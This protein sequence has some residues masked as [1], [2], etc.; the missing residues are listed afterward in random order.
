M[1]KGKILGAIIGTCFGGPWGALCGA[2][3]GHYFVD[4]ASS[5][6]A[7]SED[8]IQRI[9]TL[10]IRAAA[11]MAKADGVVSQAELN[12]VETFFGQIN[13]PLAQVNRLKIEFNNAINSTQSLNSIVVEFAKVASQE[14]N[15][16]LF[17]TL[18]QIAIAD[19]AISTKEKSALIEVASVLGI[20]DR[21]LNQFLSANTYEQSDLA[22]AYKT[23]GISANASIDE[24]KKAY[25]E[26]CKSLHPDMLA[27][28]GVS[29]LI[30]KL[31]ENELSR[32][33]DAYQTIKKTR[34]LF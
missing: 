11:K 23:L 12:E 4:S 5:N 13:L 28:K 30:V 7:E 19:G 8:R 31:A 16:S 1:F 6:E 18:A 20:S 33:N 22:Q 21:D 9:L 26:K 32:V 24:V 10:Y 15:A 17:N 34:G 14:L 27:S 2:A 25:K 3:L 29:E